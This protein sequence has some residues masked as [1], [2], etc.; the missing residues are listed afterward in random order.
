MIFHIT[1]EQWLGWKGST[2]IFLFM[3]F[4]VYVI[5]LLSAPDRILP[6][7]NNLVVF[8]MKP[9]LGETS[10]MKAVREKV[11]YSVSDFILKSICLIYFILVNI[12]FDII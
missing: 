4:F 8:L 9:L 7:E 1:K 10:C 3:S 12:V 2:K 11:K 5:Y 6:W